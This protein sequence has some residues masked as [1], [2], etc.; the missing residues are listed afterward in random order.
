MFAS[1]ADGS[2]LRQVEEDLKNADVLR[3]LE[4]EWLASTGLGDQVEPLLAAFRARGGRVEFILSFGPNRHGEGDDQAAV[5][6]VPEA[7]TQ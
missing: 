1:R 3:V 7:S 4:A 5:R 6:G 2:L